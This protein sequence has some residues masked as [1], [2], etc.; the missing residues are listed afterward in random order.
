MK[1]IYVICFILSLSFM[2][3]AQE[4]SLQLTTPAEVEISNEMNL[5]SKAVLWSQMAVGAT[6]YA[7]QDFEAANAAYNC[8]AADDFVI[9]S[10]VWEITSIECYGEYGTT[11]PLQFLNIHFYEDNSGQPGT[12]VQEFLSVPCVTQNK[13]GIVTA[14]LPS[15]LTLNTGTYWISIVARMDYDPNGQWWWYETTT[16]NL[17]MWHWRNPGDG[18]GSGF[19]NW[20]VASA[21][22]AT[23][24]ND[25]TFALNGTSMYTVTFTV[26][27][28]TNP[29]E[30]ANISI[31]SQNLTTDASGVATINLEDNTYPYDVTLT[32]Y[33]A[34]NG[35]VT[36][37]GANENVPVVLTP[38]GASI[39]ESSLSF[40]ISPNPCTDFI[41]VN[42]NTNYI[43]DVMDI[44]GRTLQS[45]Q[46]SNGKISVD[47]SSYPCGIYIIRLN[48]E[49]N[50]AVRK[51]V[52]E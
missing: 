48:Y 43:I 29:L 4:N 50:T 40:S 44:T 22:W 37:N 10:G 49:G 36:V 30:N 23:A 15:A 41:T 25:M 11:G 26:T 47:M 38:S 35:S 5:K 9:T 32:G 39:E 16:S 20:T 34:Y 42:S 21:N 51:I 24:A 8:Q 17:S 31:N 2:T 52:K 19:T 28:G 27:D 7:S 6:G 12:L 1:K 18:F 14:D 13:S 46:L 33:N 3:I 45:L